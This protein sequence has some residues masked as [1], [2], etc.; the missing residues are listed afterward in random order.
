MITAERTLITPELASRYLGT[1]NGNRGIRRN[2]VDSYKSD[3]LQG[4]WFENGDAI[5][6][7]EDGSLQD[8]HHR[9]TAC[10]ESGISFYSIV[11]R[12]VTKD[13]SKTVDKGATRSNK[14][15]L[16][17]HHGLQAEDAG[18]VASMITKVITHDYGSESWGHSSGGLSKLTTATKT[19]A[20]FEKNKNQ[21]LEAVEFCKSVVGRGNTMLPKADVAALL[22]L[23]SRVNGEVCEEFLS[24]VF[25]G[26]GITAG[27]NSDHARTILL[28]CA[29]GAKRMTKKERVYT[30]AKCMKSEISGRSIKFKSNAAYR[31]SQDKTPFFGVAK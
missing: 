6:F 3:M 22:F 9:L 20:F 11:V 19:T 21:I 14:D 10:I 2:K 8:G 17:M 28:S 15:E 4:N 1:S 12:G 24:Q 16:S 25:T 26:Y 13:A 5:R 23:W 31:K 7:Y 29:M 30:V 27:S 18:I